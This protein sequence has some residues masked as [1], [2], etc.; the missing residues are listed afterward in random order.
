MIPGIPACGNMYEIDNEIFCRLSGYPNIFALGNTVTGRGNIKESMDHGRE[1][2]QNVI[3]GYLTEAEGEP[4]K[5]AMER[6]ALA[7]QSIE[8]EIR[9][10]KI[11]EATYRQILVKVKAF[12]DRTGYDD[13]Y[14][15]WVSKHLPMRLEN[16]LG[17]KH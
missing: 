8:S 12:Q 1:I 4:N 17:A 3:E 2:A 6:I 5:G 16:I 13:N 14:R 15:K 9:E 10:H 7:L 11:D